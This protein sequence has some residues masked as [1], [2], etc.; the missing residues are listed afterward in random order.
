VLCDDM[1]LGKTVQ[2]T[3][4]RRSVAMMGRVVSSAWKQSHGRQFE[5]WM[6]VSLEN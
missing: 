6:A 1:G 4:G 2:V 5:S 3:G